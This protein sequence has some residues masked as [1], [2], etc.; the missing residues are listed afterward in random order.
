MTFCFQGKRSTNRAKRA[1]RAFNLPEDRLKPLMCTFGTFYTG[2]PADR[3]LAYGVA[4]LVVAWL[5]GRYQL[6]SMSPEGLPIVN[7]DHA[8]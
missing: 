3:I 5:N 7:L 2:I 6:R 1:I 4:L 8:M